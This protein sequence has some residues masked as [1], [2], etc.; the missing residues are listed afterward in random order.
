MS[1]C[2]LVGEPT[3]EEEEYEDDDPNDNDNLASEA[4]ILRF[5]DKTV[6]ALLCIVLRQHN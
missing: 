5:F 6:N 1:F 3:E 4:M 2:T